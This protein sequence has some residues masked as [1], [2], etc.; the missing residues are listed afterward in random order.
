MPGFIEPGFVEPGF[1]FGFG[2]VEPGFVVPPFGVVLG[3]DGEDGIVPPFG[4]SFGMV[5]VFGLSG[6]VVVEGCE[7]V[8]E[9][10][11]F[12]GF[13]PGW[14]DPGWLDPGWFELEPE[15]VGG[16]V[17]LPVGGCAVLPVGG[18]DGEVWP[19]FPAPAPPGEAVPPAGAACAT[20]QVAQPR[21][22]ESKAIFLA[23]IVKP[24]PIEFFADPFLNACGMRWSKESTVPSVKAKAQ[25]EYPADALGSDY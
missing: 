3:F 24:P 21:T 4:L 15:P 8:P 1:A 18:A 7:P 12:V 16:A 5:P 9:V 6:F 13:D 25:R 10:F 20:I 17:V 2:V 14:V 19:A 23:D 22:T 11:G